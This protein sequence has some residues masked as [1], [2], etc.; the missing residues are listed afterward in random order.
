LAAHSLS[1]TQNPYAH[2]R[3]NTPASAHSPR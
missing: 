1:H 3:T 2:G